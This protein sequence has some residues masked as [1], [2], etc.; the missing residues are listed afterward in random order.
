MRS[1]YAPAAAGR[2]S[3][4]TGWLRLRQVIEERGGRFIVEGTLSAQERLEAAKSDLV[5]IRATLN[6]RPFDFTAAFDEDAALTTGE[7]RVRSLPRTM[8]VDELA[9]INA[10]MGVPLP[11]TSY[12]V[13]PR[14]TTACDLYGL[15]ILAVRTL[16]THTG[17]PLPVAVDELMSLARRAA[18]ATGDDL[19]TRIGVVISSDERFV[20]G[21]GARHL[22]IETAGDA[23][24]DALVPDRLWV[25]VLAM[26][27]RCM[28][29]VTG[30]AWRRDLGDAP[31]GAPE[32]VFDGVL[33]DLY[34]LIRG[35]RGM[36]VNSRGQSR[37]IRDVVRGCLE[38]L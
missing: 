12:E 8:E 27:V 31:E 36:L 10:A 19:P 30:D 33:D 16:L 2:A 13:L 24:A 32:K 22:M 28:T 17:R 23:G 6:R 38:A 18:E 4:G 14:L 3:S 21:L 37:E 26:M 5:L 7:V 34:A 25:R 35:C 29:G 9:E 20:A 1:V 11:D 15:G